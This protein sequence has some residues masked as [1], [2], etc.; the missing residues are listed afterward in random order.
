MTKRRIYLISVS[1][2]RTAKF[3]GE[4]IE[5]G[6]NEE[7]NTRNRNPHEKVTVEPW[8]DRDKWKNI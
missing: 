7:F 6:I 2:D 4:M 1:S 3:V 5:K 8:N